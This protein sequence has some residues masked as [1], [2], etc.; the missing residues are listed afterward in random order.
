MKLI[1]YYQ[2]SFLG[3]I[4]LSVWWNQATLAFVHA[5][6]KDYVLP[7]RKTVGTKLLNVQYE[8]LCSSIKQ[9]VQQNAVLLIDGWK[10]SAAN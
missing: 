9:N 2:I 10:N 7:S 4:S 6:N 1:N 3:A 8:Q 5:L